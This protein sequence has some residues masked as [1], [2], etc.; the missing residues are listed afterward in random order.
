MFIFLIIIVD[1]IHEIYFNN[2]LTQF[3][4]FLYNLINFIIIHQVKFKIDFLYQLN[5]CFNFKFLNAIPQLIDLVILLRL[6]INRIFEF[7]FEFPIIPYHLRKPIHFASKFKF[8][9]RFILIIKFLKI[10]Y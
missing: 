6:P 5:C 2:C 1:L 9:N 8:P 7:K 4:I 3:F 10:I